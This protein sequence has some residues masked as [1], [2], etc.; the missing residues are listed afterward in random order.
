M[1]LSADFLD[2]L[3]VFGDFEV[4][5]MIVGGYAVARHGRPRATKDLDIW[6]EAS[7]SNASRVIEALREFGAPLARA[8]PAR[9]LDRSARA[10][11]GARAADRARSVGLSPHQHVLPRT[12]VGGVHTPDGQDSAL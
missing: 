10:A 3:R 2:L 4:R 12:S 7:P 11:V 6:I 9:Q 8:W 5:S 1:K